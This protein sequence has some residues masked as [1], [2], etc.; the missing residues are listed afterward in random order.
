[1]KQLYQWMLVLL[2]TRTIVTSALKK[3]SVRPLTFDPSLLVFMSD[4]SS[5]FSYRNMLSQTLCRLAAPLLFPS[6]FPPY[7][8]VAQAR[9]YFTSTVPDYIRNMLAEEQNSE[10]QLIGTVVRS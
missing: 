5:V 4:A 3:L 2:N 6:S 10:V 7:C 9:G 1:V 8:D